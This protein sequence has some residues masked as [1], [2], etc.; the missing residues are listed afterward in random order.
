MALTPVL[1]VLSRSDQHS[2]RTPPASNRTPERNEPGMSLRSNCPAAF[3]EK[4]RER[5]SANTPNAHKARITRSS[6]A[7]L[8]PVT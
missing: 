8:A 4:W 7:A 1:T 5:D 3:S 6:A 2:N